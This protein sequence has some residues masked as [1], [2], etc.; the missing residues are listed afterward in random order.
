MDSRMSFASKVLLGLGLG[1][2]VGITAGEQVAFLGLAGRGFVLLL[3]MAVFPFV[4][5][6][7]IAGLAGLSPAGARSLVRYAGGFLLLIWAAVLVI[8]LATPL[9]FPDWPAASYFSATLVEE[10]TS[11]DFIGAYIPANPFRSLSEGIV[12]A[13]VFFSIA[14]GLALMASERKAVL[15]ESFLAAQDALRRV[16]SAVVRLA[17]YGLFAIAAEAAG[18][19]APGRLAGLQVYVVIHVLL[20]LLLAFWVLPA[21]VA[22][23]TPFSYRETLGPARDAL[24]TVFAT[25]SLF[26]ALP[27]LNDRARTLLAERGAPE[28]AGRQVDVVVP[29][30]FTLAGA[31]KLL[32]LVFVLYAGWQSG[33]PVSPL[34]YPEFAVTGLFSSFASSAVSLPFLLDLLRI[35]SDM[36]QLYLAVDSVIGGRFSALTGASGTLALSL[37]AGCGAAGWVRFRTR[38]LAVWAIASALLAALALLA[39]RL[40]FERF[41]RPYEGYRA[42]IERSFSLPVVAWRDRNDPPDAPATYSGDALRRVRQRGALRVGYAPDRLPYAFRNDR[43][44][45]VGFDVEM[46]H[47]LARDLDVRRVEFFRVD[48]ERLPALLDSGA[49]DVAMTGLEITPERL[50]RM[51]FSAHYLQETLAFVVRDY[52]RD[53]FR[54]RGAVQAIPA[55]RLAVPRRGYYAAKIREFLPQAEI[56]V[57]D[58]PRGFFRA[59]DG[60]FDA[61]VFAAEPGSAWTL[62][63]P[64]FTVAVP[65][66][67]LLRV[68]VGYATARDDRRMADFIDSWV[69]LKRSDR[70]ID[71]LFG[72]WF[73]GE[74]PVGR[75]RR[76]SLARDVFGWGAAETA[77]PERSAEPVPPTPRPPAATPPPPPPPESR[78]D[79][80][81][82]PDDP[83]ALE[84]RP[85]MPDA[86]P[87]EAAG[88][89]GAVPPPP[90]A[91][92][93][94]PPGAEPALIAE[95]EDHP[96]GDAEHHP[97]HEGV[98]ERAVQLRHEL[99][100]HA[101]DPREEGEGDEDA[102]H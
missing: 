7:L 56:S 47:A 71:R 85:A 22:A 67:V 97:E 98:A 89:P 6:S 25:G 32:G 63:Y 101:V 59:A 95:E 8:V 9:A 3:Q 2:V 66:P 46:A 70:T 72:Y 55:L 30:A 62:I 82:D 64:Q 84:D 34:E 51:N 41:D 53:Q 37:L 54:T 68:P 44:E 17:P 93:P 100:V 26:I 13:V 74:D 91:S 77:E 83:D 38:R 39:I 58:S 42:F 15:L 79:E 4:A 69:A 94:S 48:I 14:F 75:K 36:F 12:P 45:L 81:A 102:R 60:D 19:M 23:V 86:G 87:G 40:G 52:R 76:W 92:V 96:Q 78:G 57:I 99:E 1:V 21:L 20:S 5:V 35:P 33:Y 27:I 61:L 24:V 29:I 90:P 49:L 65:H 11:F 73:E 28:E 80:P 16:T 88:E 50:E 43:G 18:T 10:R 31:G